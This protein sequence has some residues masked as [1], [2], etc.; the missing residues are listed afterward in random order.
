MHS[1][2]LAVAVGMVALA[3]LPFAAQERT[4]PDATAINA[5]IRQEGIRTSCTRCTTSRTSMGRD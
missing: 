3:A 1:R 2:T 5:K 4:S